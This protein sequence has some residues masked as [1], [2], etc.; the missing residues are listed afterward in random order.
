MGQPTLVAR[1][2]AAVPFIAAA[3]LLL[4]AACKKQN[5]YVAPPPAQLGVAAP[6]RQAVTPYLELTGNTVAVNSVDLVA[7]V[8]GFLQE[9]DYRDGA[10]VRKGTPLFVIEPAPFQAK[11]RQA[12]AQAQS[13][14]AQLSQTQADFLRQ[15]D[16][17]KKGYA[18]P[19][20]LD[21]SRAQRDT[22]QAN[23][24][25]AQ[26]GVSLAAI[27]LG[28][29]TVAAPFDGVVSAHLQAVGALVGVTG[30]TQLA[31]IVQID[32]IYV[33]FA[34]SEQQVLRIRENLA[35]HGRTLAQVGTVP[36]DIGLMTEQGYPH[37]GALDYVAPQLDPTTGTL[38]VRALF[39]N[40]DHR[41]LPGLFVRIRLPLALQP[42]E[43]M[44][45][46]D[47]AL[48]TSQAGPYLLVVNKADVVEQR[49]V[50]TGQL[51]G[52]LRVISSGLGADDRVVVS[53][54]ARAVPGA[55]VSAQAT[56]IGDPP[57][58]GASAP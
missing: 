19:S 41:L 7:R 46:P 40:S 13:T 38:S 45:V 56:T 27:D 6:L 55:K 42:Q 32:P 17:A 51:F 16:L 35:K 20:A 2:T 31:T 36:V 28:Y 50:E 15:S 48:G 25:N 23:L 10:F 24:L 37:R 44:L 30:P 9:I 8:E 18:T 58:G 1:P 26:A 29:T 5:D 43:A 33:T 57:T 52:Q 11:L 4:I 47:A 49:P 34:L 39:E 12:Q 14:Q 53:G 3:L 21:Q 22:Q 54:L